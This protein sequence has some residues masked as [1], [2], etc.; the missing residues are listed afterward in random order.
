MFL[1]FVD[2]GAVGFLLKRIRNK[3]YNPAPNRMAKMVSITQGLKVQHR[4]IS[5]TLFKQR[6]GFSIV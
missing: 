2:G 3:R 5:I 4:Y 6:N 1:W